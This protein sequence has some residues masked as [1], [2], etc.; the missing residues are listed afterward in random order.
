VCFVVCSTWDDS[1][2]NA[3]PRAFVLFLELQTLWEASELGD[4]MGR[5]FLSL[6]DVLQQ[7]KQQEWNMNNVVDTDKQ[8]AR[9]Q[10]SYWLVGSF[11]WVC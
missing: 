3:N 2:P 10:D 8:T 7:Q 9:S 6:S 1:E 5:F 11:L 4:E